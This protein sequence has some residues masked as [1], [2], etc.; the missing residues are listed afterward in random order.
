MCQI[1]QVLNAMRR[2]ENVQAEV[3]FELIDLSLD[4]L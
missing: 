2:G 3:R 1:R 4:S